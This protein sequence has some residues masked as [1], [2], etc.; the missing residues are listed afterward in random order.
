MSVELTQPLT[1]MSTRDIFWMVNV[2]GELG[3]QPYHLHVLIA[4]KSR[5]LNLLEP[6]RPVQACNGIVLPLINIGFYTAIVYCN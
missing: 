6:F 4:L 2:A 1:E 5:S 3:C